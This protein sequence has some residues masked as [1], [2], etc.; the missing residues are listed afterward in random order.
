MDTIL[1]I[2]TIVGVVIL[3]GM[4]CYLSAENKHLREKIKELEE[5]R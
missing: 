2:L 3:F 4:V 1:N 5:R